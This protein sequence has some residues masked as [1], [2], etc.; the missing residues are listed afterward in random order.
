M[1]ADFAAAA[2]PSRSAPCSLACRRLMIEAKPIFFSSGTAVALIAPAHATVVS[3]RLKFVTPSS[4][5]L[6]TCCARAGAT[7]THSA[8]T[9]AAIMNIRDRMSIP[10]QAFV[11]RNQ[12]YATDRCDKA[13]SYRNLLLLEGFGQSGD[14]LEDVADDTVVGDFKDGGVGVLI[15][16]DD[17]ARTF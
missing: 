17:G 16:G 9:S 12:N 4:V 2:S 8:K 6:V 5:S 1:S 15:D 10:P 11:F 13:R 3:S 14:E 7:A